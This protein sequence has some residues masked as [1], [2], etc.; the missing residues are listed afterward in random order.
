[1]RALGSNPSWPGLGRVS[2]LYLFLAAL[3]LPGA[4]PSSAQ[5]PAP[6][7]A[8]AEEIE[9]QKALE[10]IVGGSKPIEAW[11]ADYVMIMNLQGMAMTS[12]GKM[13]VQGRS[14]RNEMNLDVMGQNM[15][16]LSVTDPQGVTW[17]ESN[18]LGQ[19]MVMKMDLKHMGGVGGGG[20]MMGGMNPLSNETSID[21][22]SFVQFLQ[23]SPEV[24]YLGKQDLE[25]D[26]VLGFELPLDEELRKTF[27]SGGQLTQMGL[28]PEKVQMMISP[29]DGFPRLWQ[30]VD[31]QDKPLTSMI[32]RN[33]R[34]NPALPADRFSYTPAEGAQVMDMTALAGGMMQ[35][36]GAMA[37]G[38]ETD[39]GAPPAAGSGVPGESRYNQKYKAGDVAP[40]F[41]A[42]DRS[43]KKISL[44][45]LRGKVVLLDFWAT[46]CGPCVQELPNVIAA[47]EKHH[48][49]GFEIVGISLD[50]DAEALATFLKNQPGMT[51]PQIFDG[52]GWSSEVAQLYGIEAIPHAVLLDKQGTI[53]R[54]ALRGPALDAAIAELLAKP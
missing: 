38:D 37:S 21:P 3:W 24:K 35:D 34:L 20:A 52:K 48:S 40:D 22:R 47:Y 30:V 44:A 45:S 25:G 16:M 2:R 49:A 42:T 31:A 36:M 7:P 53:Y 29:K 28:K 5:E 41:T 50:D 27:D 13:E 4:A 39:L 17:I 54:T 12:D 43:G 23:E 32:Y 10:S 46:W 26:E 1:M 11:A 33:V 9:K 6:A 14:V 51:W 15:T 19:A 18:L 8:G